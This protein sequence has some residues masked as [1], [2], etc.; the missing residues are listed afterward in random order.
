MIEKRVGNTI[1]IIKGPQFTNK[2]HLNQLW[3]HLTDEADSEPPEET[4][5][6]VIYVTFRYSDHSSGSQ[7][8]L[9]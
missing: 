8:A 1:Y 6:D 9:C 7:N 4:V 5:M 3:K 2:R